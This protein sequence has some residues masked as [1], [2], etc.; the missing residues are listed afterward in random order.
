MHRSLRLSPG[1]FR[2]RA[3]E[4]EVIY[5]A[6]TVQQLNSTQRS[7]ASP[8]GQS[9][10]QLGA[11]EEERSQYLPYS[12]SMSVPGPPQLRQ[13]SV[14]QLGA[15]PRR[16]RRKPVS[17]VPCPFPSVCPPSV[18]RQL[19]SE[20]GRPRRRRKPVSTVPLQLVRPSPPSVPHAANISKS[21]RR[22]ELESQPY[23]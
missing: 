1:A 4:E 15:R 3:K 17:T 16:G 22:K 9:V 19:S 5:R 7:R 12:Y 13:S 14:T 8:P 20:P 23:M 11:A 21:G 6:A 10:T 18:S 2:R